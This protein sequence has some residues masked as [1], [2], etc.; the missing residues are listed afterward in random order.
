MIIHIM[1]INLKLF[2]K[3]HTIWP[4]INGHMDL[5][6]IPSRL[7]IWILYG[8]PVIYIYFNKTNN[9]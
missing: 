2:S 8:F 3:F 9:I 5:E 4:E 6:P 1:Y 7:F